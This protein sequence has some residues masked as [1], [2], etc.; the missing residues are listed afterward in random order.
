MDTVGRGTRTAM[1]RAIE[2]NGAEFLL[3]MGRAAGAEEIAEPRLH[4][5][6]GGSPLA[7]HNSVVRADL[8]PVEADAA[9]AASVE[10]FRAHGV[11]GSWHVG[12]SMRPADLGT[13]LLAHGFTH[14]GED[15]GMA[16]DLAALQQ[17]LPAPAGL[18]VE[19][20]RDDGSLAA[21]AGVLGRSFGEGEAEAAWVQATYRRIGLGD[22]VPW[23]YYLGRLE[24]EP[25]A[26]AT[27]FISGD[28]AGVYFV[29]TLPSARRQGIGAAVTR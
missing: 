19:R 20:V 21:W 16:A 5:T 12:P 29:S 13:R 9:I 25:V 6:I 28:A 3:A 2:D 22:D 15:I 17:N 27:L 14:V 1:V 11:P 7:Y 23:R 18:I 8:P 24:G 4:W 26:T 10:R